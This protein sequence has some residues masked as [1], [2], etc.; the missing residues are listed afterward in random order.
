MADMASDMAEVTMNLYKHM[1]DIF[2]AGFREFGHIAKAL[3][4]G[5][6][7]TGK[8]IFKWSRDKAAPA[9]KQ[10][11]NK[12][13]K[14]I[15]FNS[16]QDAVI[17]YEALRKTGKFKDKHIELIGKC[18]IVNKKKY[19]KIGEAQLYKL[20]H[21]VTQDKEG[22]KKKVKH[23]EDAFKQFNNLME[24][25]QTAADDFHDHDNPKIDNPEND[26]PKIDNPEKSKIKDD[27]LVRRKF[28]SIYE[29]VKYKE[30][31]LAK[32]HVNTNEL[33]FKPD[34]VKIQGTTVIFPKREVKVAIKQKIEQKVPEFDTQD[35]WKNV[36]RIAGSKNKKNSEMDRVRRNEKRIAGTGMSR[37]KNIKPSIKKMPKGKVK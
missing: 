10:H 19:N 32:T 11:L 3:A 25:S 4:K 15:E 34:E 22:I 9:I 37:N 29:A 24:K 7:N 18:L 12:D 28:D 36:E 33:I 30:E 17:D 1:F 20:R 26:D 23:Y 27:N 35:K 8:G 31:L 13:Q 5:T 16:V 14:L 2:F 6:W 21:E